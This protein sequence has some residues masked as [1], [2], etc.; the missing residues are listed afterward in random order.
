MDRLLETYTYVSNL[1]DNLILI[2]N[3]EKG[4][5]DRV[6]NN[7]TIVA[8]NISYKEFSEMFM[9]YYNLDEDSKDKIIRFFDGF[10]PSREHFVINP[11]FKNKNGETV[12]LELRGYKY[13]S[14]NAILSF[15][16]RDTQESGQFDDLTKIL[17]RDGIQPMIHEFIESSNPFALIFLDIDDFDDFNDKYGKIYGDIV[18]LEVSAVIKDFIKSDGYVARIGADRFLILIKIEDDFDYIHTLCTALRNTVISMTNHNIKQAQITATIGC[19]TFP[20]DGLT[21]EEIYQKAYLALE[22]GKKKGKNCFIIYTAK[23]CGIPDKLV[24]AE[25]RSL[26]SNKANNFNIISGI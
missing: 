20:H 17:T 7:S 21:Y 22:R 5:I 24:V 3:I 2:V 9:E 10:N 18:L 19:A 8:T 25:K 23:K 1:Y 4:I 14:S 6:V 16:P 26:E 11:N 15:T 12:R 13:D